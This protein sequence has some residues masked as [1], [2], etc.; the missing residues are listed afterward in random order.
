MIAIRFEDRYVKMPESYEVSR[1]LE[2]F[3]VQELSQAFVDYDT[4]KVSGSRYKLPAGP[5]LVLLL[6]ADEGKGALWTTVRSNRKMPWGDKE[7]YYRKHI[8]EMVMCQVVKKEQK[9]LHD[10]LESQLRKS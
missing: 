7:S 10:E 3:S 9:T 8:G 2:V 5:K 1:L 6:Q 4:L